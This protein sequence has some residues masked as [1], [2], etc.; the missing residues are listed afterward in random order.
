MCRRVYQYGFVDATNEE[1]QKLRNEKKNLTSSNQ[2]RARNSLSEIGDYSTISLQHDEEEYIASLLSSLNESLRGSNT[3]VERPLSYNEL[4]LYANSSSVSAQSRYFLAKSITQ[5]KLLIR[6]LF[7]QNKMIETSNEKLAFLAIMRHVTQQGS[8]SYPYIYPLTSIEY[9]LDLKKCTVIKPLSPLGN[10]SQFIKNNGPLS[11]FQIS[12]FGRQILLG[13]QHLERLMFP[14]ERFSLK[15]DCVQVTSAASSKTIK[16]KEARYTCALS[17]LENA[18]LLHVSSNLKLK[19]VTQ[20]PNATSLALSFGHL[21]YDMASPLQSAPLRETAQLEAL[22]AIPQLFD[23]LNT[24]FVSNVD[25]NGVITINTLLMHPFFNYDEVK[26]YDAQLPLSNN[27]KTVDKLNKRVETLL[28]KMQDAKKF[29]QMQ[30]ASYRNL[31]AM[32]TASYNNSNVSPTA[33]TTAT[34]TSAPSS[35]STAPTTA[36]KAP[37][38]PVAPP[39][40]P[41]PSTSA[42]PPP[43]PPPTGNLSA[44][45]AAVLPPPQ[46]E[47]SGLLDEIRRGTRL[48][49]RSS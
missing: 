7:S 25:M 45:T 29:K 41:P 36:A 34:T 31:V 49:L 28:I 13:A 20:A 12:L 17:N 15:M 8:T 44:Q 5:H 11:N 14:V 19:D 2:I 24:I 27:M 4:C 38:A 9:M 37:A 33:T 3:S 46:A 47:R 16:D 1:R 22:R 6:I 21:L 35:S 40:P 39:P 26:K 32:E 43:P 48:T 23:V 18:F 10:L 42:P 30:R